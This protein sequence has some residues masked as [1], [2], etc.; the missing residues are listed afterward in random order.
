MLIIRKLQQYKS[1]FQW[2]GFFVVVFYAIQFTSPKYSYFQD[3]HDKLVQ[4]YSVWK[5]DFKTD[6]LYYPAYQF[7]SKLVYFHLVNNL[8]LK[9]NERLVSAFPIQFAYLLAPFLIFLHPSQMVYTSLLFLFSSF[10]IL[11]KY[12]KFSFL[13]LWFSFFSTFLWPLSWEYSEFPAVFCF[14][15]LCL[16]PVL[17]HKRN[18]LFQILCGLGLSWVVMVRLDTLPFL[19]SF[20]F[21]YFYF[22]WK[23][24]DTKSFAKE[25]I[26]LQFFFLAGII[27][28]LIQFLINQ[29]L[30]QHF[31]GTRF[32]ANAQGLTVSFDERLRWFQTLLF[33][34]DKKIGFFLYLPLSILVIGFY[35]KYFHSIE[36]RKKALFVAMNITLLTIPFLAPN[37]GFNNWGPRFYT[38]LIL[39]Y[40]ILFK[41]I[42]TLILRRKRFFFLSIFLFFT[43]FSVMLGFLGAK[44]QKS[45]TS[46]LKNFQ[47]ITNEIKPDVFVFTDYLNIYSIGSDYTKQITLVSYS[48]ES[49]TK[50]IRLLRK[51]L[52]NKKIAFVDW[53]P[54]I[55]TPEIRQAMDADKIKGNYPVSH[56]DVNQLETDLK[57]NTKDYQIIDRQMYRIWTGIIK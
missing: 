26:S 55:L 10:Y 36:K 33:Y 30:Y 2:V 13:F 15:T 16:L 5:N 25:V 9:V 18:I 23:E 11:R 17:K 46:L 38:I 41:P 28:I 1:G 53:H 43:L 48:T 29:T 54:T 22:H 8:Y 57:P 40:L 37:D 42:L 45:K 35:K 34:S 50:L 24:T 52:P 39:P 49:N 47:T 3:S 56:W 51:E 27:G 4:T 6:Q 20:L 21:F 31:L 12:Y 44:I 32:L 7:D 19:F 14:A